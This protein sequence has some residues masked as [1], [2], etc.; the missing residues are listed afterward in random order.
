MAASNIFLHREQELADLNHITRRERPCLVIVYGRRRVGKSTLIR[1]WATQ[2][3]LPFFYWESP[4]Q[5]DDKVRASLTR[6]LLLWAGES[7]AVASDRSVSG[8]WA[9]VFRLMR[10]VIGTRPT[11]VAI[12]EFP[13][14]VEANDGLPS[15][16]KTAW[17]GVLADTQLK[18]L[19]AGSH[20]SAMEKLLHSDAALFGRFEGKLAVHPFPFPKIAPFVPHYTLEKRLAVYAILGGVPDYLRRWDDRADLMRNIRDIFLSDL[21]PFRNEHQI[22]IS[23]VLRRDSPDYESVLSAVGRGEHELEAITLESS[24]GSTARASGV[25]STL[26]EIRLVEKRIRASVKP[27]DQADARYARYHLADPFLQ[28]YYRFVEPN[29]SRIVLGL[30]DEIEPIFRE[31]LRGFVGYAFE[32]LCRQW[33]LVKARNAELPFSPEFIGSDWG[34]SYQADVVAINWTQR[35]V[36]IGEAKWAEDDMDH[37]RWRDFEHSVNGVMNRLHAIDAREESKA[38]RLAETRSKHAHRDGTS[39][40]AWKCHLAI[41]VRRGVTA[42]VKDAA[43][44]VKAQVIPFKDVVADLERLPE[45]PIR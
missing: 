40:P 12:D 2:T 1:H 39:R 36:F 16:L 13:W 42:A 18:L 22:L 35:E 4:R 30:Y 9:S 17:D 19:I 8:D 26:E 33:T 10:R 43:R 15:L 38:K 21:S 6:E 23:D 3:G 27:E 14:A 34:S 28:F 45:K 29:R 37:Q 7:A 11:I 31:Q 20:I 25:L 24:V 32:A 5:N 41:F 44:T